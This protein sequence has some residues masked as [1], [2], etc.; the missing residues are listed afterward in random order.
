MSRST[1]QA[2]GS[3]AKLHTAPSFYERAGESKASPRG[4][5]WCLG[6][7]KAKD[8]ATRLACLSAC[9]LGGSALF[10]ARSTTLDTEQPSTGEDV[11]R[12]RS[13]GSLALSLKQRSARCRRRQGQKTAFK[14]G[15]GRVLS[16]RPLQQS[17]AGGPFE[18]SNV[19]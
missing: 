19:P 2:T 16:R 18:R 1:F 12:P 6:L 11:G 15:S 14:Q 5:P 3:G 17:R 10:N 8:G 4:R 9:R 7:T 13:T